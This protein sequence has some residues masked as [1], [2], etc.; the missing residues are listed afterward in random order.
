M[1]DPSLKYTLST[2]STNQL[3]DFLSLLKMSILTTL[4]QLIDIEICEGM[5][6][7]KE[8]EL[9]FVQRMMLHLLSVWII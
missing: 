4:C 7:E 2:L 3:L 8:I 5:E 6:T 1:S 9:V